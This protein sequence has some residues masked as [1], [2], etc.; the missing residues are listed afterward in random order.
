MITMTLADVFVLGWSWF[1]H[2]PPLIPKPG[3]NRP[4]FP[5]SIAT[6]SCSYFIGDINKAAWWEFERQSCWLR[7]FCL[8]PV[9]KACVNFG[10]SLRVKEGGDL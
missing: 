9:I 7:V 8:V 10:G 1:E 3:G 2:S 4:S 5:S 6:T